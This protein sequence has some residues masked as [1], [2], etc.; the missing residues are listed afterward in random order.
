MICLKQ[1]LIDFFDMGQRITQRIYTCDLCGKTPD[2]GEYM[3]HMCNE[4]WCKECCDKQEQIS[5]FYEQQNK[6]D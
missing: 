5:K 6:N 2:D 1:K 4:V 3:W